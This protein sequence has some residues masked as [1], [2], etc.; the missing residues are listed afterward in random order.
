MK[1]GLYVAF[2]TTMVTCLLLGA[3]GCGA[4]MAPLT[5]Q[6]DEHRITGTQF[7]PTVEGAIS[8]V[9]AFDDGDIA[10]ASEHGLVVR[11]DSNGTELWRTSLGDRLV[12]EVLAVPASSHLLAASVSVSPEGMYSDCRVEALDEHGQHVWTIMPP[13]TDTVADI[14]VGEGEDLALLAFLS[15]Y[16]GPGELLWVDPMTGS[17]LKS[18]PVDESTMIHID[19]TPGLETVAL[20]T[21][22]HTDDISTLA[23][24]R[25]TVFNDMAITLDNVQ[26]P[27]AVPVLVDPQSL[28]TVDAEGQMTR[29]GL[30][31]GKWAEG[32]TPE[33]LGAYPSWLGLEGSTL[34]LASQSMVQEGDDSHHIIQLTAQ[35]IGADE[36]LWTRE[37]ETTSMTLLS[38]LPERRWI[39]A[40]APPGTD[41]EAFLID[42]ADGTLY[43]LPAG[44]TCVAASTPMILAGTDRGVLLAVDSPK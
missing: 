18:H 10:L 35:G 33:D 9:A 31:D 19:V 44:T 23:P 6:A 30:S 38:L 17:A 41:P 43:S 39:V 5:A 24:G 32:P 26:E 12:Y 40:A 34:L 4:D 20:S 15:I 36:A 2:I 13:V 37:Y 3:T 25:L 1:V 11:M 21:V 8:A 14:F 22:G 16:E 42:V 7:G 27:Y 29:W 28:V